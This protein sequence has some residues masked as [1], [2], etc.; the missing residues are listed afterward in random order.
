MEDEDDEEEEE[1]EDE[2]MNEEIDDPDLR[3]DSKSVEESSTSSNS[4]GNPDQDSESVDQSPLEGS[5]V[6][7]RARALL[8]YG[9]HCKCRTCVAQRCD[10]K[11]N[12]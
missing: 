3:D 4:V 12:S 6:E 7:E 1:E 5:T 10:I 8:E 11:M 2:A 9:F